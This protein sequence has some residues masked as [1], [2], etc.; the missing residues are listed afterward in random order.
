MVDLNLKNW[1]K[2]NMKSV[3]DSIMSLFNAV[4]QDLDDVSN[5][6]SG[7]N[8]RV[9]TLESN[10]ASG[11]VTGPSSS[12]SNGVVIFDGTTGKAIKDSG[13][14]I[15]KSVPSNAVFTD[16]T[17]ESKTAASGGTAV[18][19]VT[20]GE[21]YTWNNKGNGT[22][23]SVSTGA[24]LTGGSITGSGTI[25]AKLRSETQS[26]L[27]S[28][29]KGSTSNREYAVGLDS[30]GYLSV[31]I[32][33]ENTQT[34]T[35]VKGDSESSYRTGNVSITPAN[36]GLGN[37]ENKSASTI[38]GELTKDMLLGLLVRN[39]FVIVDTPSS[40]IAH[41]SNLDDNGKV[42][43]STYNN[44]DAWTKV[45]T[46]SGAT[47]L[48]VIVVCQSESTGYDWGCVWSGSYSSYT[49]A[50]NYG[51]SISGK[52]GGTTKQ[53]L[54]FLVSSNSA[55]IAWK[56]DGSGNQY[57]GFYAAAIPLYGSIG[58]SASISAYIDTDTGN[59]MY[60]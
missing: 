30:S 13:Y 22:V 56:T 23:T 20:T 5:A 34:V 57:Y 16:T 35:G 31:N 4:D 58:G 40:L 24:G 32:P 42:I 17:Y 19:L 52:I 48:L 12:T 38:L 36:I 45:L 26:S 33:W 47:G 46:A 18:S 3:V 27:A 50:S 14:T 28:A 29:S 15:G 41:T 53:T 25:K 21:K 60:S 51:S 59:L 39:P 2:R 11:D 55:T 9:T 7:I 8:S 49:A 6:L 54:A 43:S 37:V 10:P 1:F 44:S